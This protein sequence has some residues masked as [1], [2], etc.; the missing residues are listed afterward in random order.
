MG[1]PGHDP[2]TGAEE[3]LNLGTQVG[4]RT[5]QQDELVPDAGRA[6]TVRAEPGRIVQPGP[7]ITS[8]SASACCLAPPHS[9]R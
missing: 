9:W 2:V 5:V 8:R 3:V 4:E 1:E 6:A 7:R